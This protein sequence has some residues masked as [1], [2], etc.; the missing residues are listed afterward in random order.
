MDACLLNAFADSFAITEA[1]VNKSPN[2]RVN[3]RAYLWIQRP[4]PA[5]ERAHAVDRKVISDLREAIGNIFDTMRASA[6]VFSLP[7][8]EQSWIA[9]L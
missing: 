3:A 9:D 5:G 7:I 4:S 1:P 2:H 6:V 8:R